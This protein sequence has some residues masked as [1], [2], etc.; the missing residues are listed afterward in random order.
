[1]LKRLRLALPFLAIFLAAAAVMLAATPAG[2]APVQ[3]APSPEVVP[4]PS[5]YASPNERIGVGLVFSIGDIVSYNVA[6]LEAGWYG[7]WMS[8]SY[9]PH[10]NG[11]DYIALI[12]TGP[13]NYPP[14]WEALTLQIQR[15]P[16]RL[17][18]VGNEPEG[19][20]QE[21]HTPAVYAQIYHDVYTF[22][23][24][25]DPT[26]Q[27]AIGGVILP[28]PLRL[29]WLDQVLQAYQTRYGDA[30]PV[31]VWN[32]HMQIV[33]EVSCSFDVDN[34]WGA[35][36]PYGLTENVGIRMNLTDNVNYDLFVQLIQGMRT[37]MNERGFRNKQL[38]VSEYGVLLPSSYLCDLCQDNPALGDPI[39]ASFM[40]RT[41]QYMLTAIDPN[42]GMPADGDR[43]VQRWMWYTLNDQPYNFDTG[44]GFNGGLFDYRNN[45]YPGTL[46]YF[47]QVFKNFVVPLKVPYV[48]VYA[49][50]FKVTFDSDATYTMTVNVANKGNS[51]ASNVKV[52]F[53]AGGP[54]GPRVQVGSD[55][56]ISSVAMRW[57]GSQKVT[58]S[59]ALPGGVSTLVFYAVVDP[60]NAIV[61][62]DKTNNTAIFT[63]Y[64]IRL[65]LP[66]IGA[67]FRF[68]SH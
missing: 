18:I 13:G 62:P 48:D 11:M 19:V 28:S 6:Q 1:M 43:L 5:L 64:P 29:K 9:P 50:D 44:L 23:K 2:A 61:E 68:A 24:S 65:F 20:D 26:A 16:G 25:I 66:V 52:R 47:G 30:M 27:V 54:V 53:Y 59:G 8:R 36:I 14:N 35:G 49:T 15:N 41:F 22:I 46:T 56:T 7:D 17:W 10:P 32:T 31:D 39:V 40:T 42:K 34:C 58:W 63:N 3:D 55:T 57:G 38:I 67:N 51:G 60:D 4:T 33:N 37:W 12:P 45:V 21:K